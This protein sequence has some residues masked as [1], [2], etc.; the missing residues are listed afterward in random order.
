M[1]TNL[2]YCL[3]AVLLASNVHAQKDDFSN[4]LPEGKIINQRTLTW[5]DFQNKEAK[6]HAEKM[7]SQGYQSQAY[8]IPAIYFKWNVGERLDN[9]RVKFSAVAKCA[10]QSHAYVKNEVKNAH[11]IY[12]YTHEHDHYDI[13]LVYAQKM[14]EAVVTKDYSEANYNAEINKILEDYYTQYDATQR[15]Y[16]GEVN[17]SGRMDTPVQAL[18]DMRIKKCLENNTLDYMNSPESVV[19]SVKGLG[20]SVKRIPNEPMRRFATRCRPL[21]SEF[22][23]ETAAMSIETDVWGLEKVVVAFYKQ[24]YFIEEEGKPT[25]DASRLMGY[26][27]VPNGSDT[28]KRIL[29]DTFCVDDMAAKVNTVFFAN[30]DSDNVK[31]VV[32]QTT[33]NRKD[34]QVVGVQYNTRVYDNVTMRALP[35]RLRRMNEVSAKLENGVDGTVDGKAQKVRLK[36]QKDLTDELIK[37]GFANEAI[38]TPGSA[39][40]RTIHQ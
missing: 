33:A 15:K 5:N 6:D 32:V 30:A 18:W 4:M 20:Q 11:S 23:D 27:F 17:P 24:R 34:K 13:A 28:Y 14:E 35:G 36:N 1:K 29:I 2:L 39:P 10:F 16:D 21:Y 40:K 37:L 22:T 38:S 26:L 25:K 3:T 19:A 8:V 7:A 12:V 9:G 31:E